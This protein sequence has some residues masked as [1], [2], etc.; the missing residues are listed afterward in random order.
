MKS[1]VSHVNVIVSAERVIEI[2][3]LP[4]SARIVSRRLQTAGGC[5]ARI[6]MW[7]TAG[8]MLASLHE[9]M[10]ARYGSGDEHGRALDRHGR[11]LADRP[12]GHGE[13]GGGVLQHRLG[14]A[15]REAE[16]PLERAVDAEA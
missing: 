12:P 9:R 13:A 5:G 15:E 14:E 2:G 7:W 4:P 8:S 11:G 6:V 10:F 3:G 1:P 16:E